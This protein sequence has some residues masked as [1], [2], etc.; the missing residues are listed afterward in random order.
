MLMPESSVNVDVRMFGEIS[1][2]RRVKS[3]TPALHVLQIR[4]L[5]FSIDMA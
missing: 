3:K 2:L 5:V 1:G 4:R